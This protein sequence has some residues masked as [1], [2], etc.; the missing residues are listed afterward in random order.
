MI[1]TVTGKNQ[2]TLLAK[3]GWRPGIRIDWEK[4]G[5]NSLIVKSLPSRGEIA[6]GVMGVASA[7]SGIDPIAELQRVQEEDS[8]F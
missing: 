1:T 6:L 5:D 2:I 7:K 8:T 3:L 4:S